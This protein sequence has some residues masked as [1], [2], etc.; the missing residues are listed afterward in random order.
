LQLVRLIGGKAWMGEPQKEVGE[1]ES[2][3][4]LE[5][6]G[7]PHEQRGHRRQIPGVEKDAQEVKVRPRRPPQWIRVCGH[8]DCCLILD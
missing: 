8:R 3:Q 4:R 6:R 1:K 5:G 7:K 2:R